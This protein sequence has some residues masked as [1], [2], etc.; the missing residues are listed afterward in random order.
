MLI[1]PAIDLVGGRCVRLSQGLFEDAT[2]YSADPA[3]AL[4]RFADAGAT[5]THV[6]D[7][8]GARERRPMQHD[9]IAGLARNARQQVQV[10]GGFRNR[11]QIARV[12]DA[13]AARIVIGS[14]AA[15]DPETTS[16]LIDEFGAD[17]ITLAL[18]VRLI[19]GAPEIATAGWRKSTGRTVWEVAELYP[20]A[21][22]AMVTDIGRDGM[23]SGPN[24][25]LIA[26]FVLRHPDL[27][28]QASGGV[29]SA[30]DL[31]AL[32]GTGAAGAI[33]GKAI[34]E[35]RLDLAE[36]IDAGG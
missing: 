11:E 20:Q 5:W 25:E 36:A 33:V 15:T 6:V 3:D 29:A 13:G 22:H 9:L 8:D 34:W 24:L 23:L 28:V 27:D 2:V 31:R 19:G 21:R 26:E 14:L 17:R 7:L 12:L 1:Y 32:R 18:D 16:L 10:A 30:E 4:E 35:A